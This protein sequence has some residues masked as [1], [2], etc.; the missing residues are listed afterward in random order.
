MAAVDV[1]GAEQR[2]AKKTKFVLRSKDV[3]CRHGARSPEQ[4]VQ[5]HSKSQG[6]G[7]ECDP[8]LGQSLRRNVGK[9]VTGHDPRGHRVLVDFGRRCP[10][11]LHVLHVQ[12]R[13]RISWEL[14]AVTVDPGTDAF[15]SPAER[16]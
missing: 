7:R 11:T 16:T 15:D 4:A 8:V 1:L 2:A 10:L 5:G 14:G 3:C 6:I 9:A 13:S 12:Q